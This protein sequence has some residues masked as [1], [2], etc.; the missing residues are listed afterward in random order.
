MSHEAGAARLPKSDI[1]VDASRMY[2]AQSP[3]KWVMNLNR[4]GIEE[5]ASR[6]AKLYEP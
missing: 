6:G 5:K 3:V 1:A 2:I 4:I